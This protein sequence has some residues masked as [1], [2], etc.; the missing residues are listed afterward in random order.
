MPGTSDPYGAFRLNLEQQRK[1]EEFIAIRGKHIA[2]SVNAYEENQPIARYCLERVQD[3]GITSIECN[4]TRVIGLSGAAVDHMLA[5]TDALLR[6]VDRRIDN[7]KD[8]LLPLVRAKPLDDVL[9]GAAPRA[10][11]GAPRPDRSRERPKR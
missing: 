11:V 1:H 10:G 5:I 9:R 3:E 6:H 8:R 7:E 4:H 2:H